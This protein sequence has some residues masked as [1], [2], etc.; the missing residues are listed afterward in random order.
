MLPGTSLLLDAIFGTGLSTPPR[1]PFEQM[2][3]TVRASRV[4]VIAV[5]LPSGMDCDT[6]Q[7]L[8]SCIIATRTVTFVAEKTGFAAP[9]AK[10]FLGEVEVGDIGLPRELVDSLGHL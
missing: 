4:P 6:G 1:P 2:V 8:G 7:P 5:D 9:G 3:D 10:A